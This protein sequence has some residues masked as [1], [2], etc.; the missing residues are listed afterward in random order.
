MEGF[1]SVI[2]GA[3]LFERGSP[4]ESQPAPRKVEGLRASV[5]RKKPRA[6]S[7]AGKVLQ[8]HLSQGM[9]GLRGLA[10]PRGCLLQIPW[11]PTAFGEHAPEPELRTREEVGEVEAEVV[12]ATEAVLCSL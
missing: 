2:T 7:A 8:Q 5:I 4:R 12:L 1:A 10:E 9:S 11:N 6:C 3:H